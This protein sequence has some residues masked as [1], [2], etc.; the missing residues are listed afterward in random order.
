MTAKRFFVLLEYTSILWWVAE[1][2]VDAN[3]I[4]ERE[5]VYYY[6]FDES[7]HPALKDKGLRFNDRGR[8]VK[9]K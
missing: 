5:L 9:I 7:G 6:I 1:G 4:N 3:K 2:V 8:L